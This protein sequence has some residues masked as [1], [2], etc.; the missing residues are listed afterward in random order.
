MKKRGKILLFLLLTLFLYSCTKTI[1]PPNFGEYQPKA[2]QV[3]LKSDPKLHLYQGIP[4][5][6][7]FCVYNLIDPNEFNQLL[8]E[9]GG[10]EK[11]C[12]CTKFHPSVTNAKRFIIH[13]NKEY[14]EVLDRP[15]NA[16]YVGV[17]A[18]YYQLQKEN[19]TRQYPHPVIEEKTWRTITQKPGNLNINLYLGPQQIKDIGGKEK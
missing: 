19:V 14:T 10:L 7:V 16:K 4:H 1:I 6:L 12:E 3:Y 8:D 18:G 15:A 9:K 5:T 17:V 2:I 11:L 13:P